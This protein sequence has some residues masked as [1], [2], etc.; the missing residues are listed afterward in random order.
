MWRS[1][2]RSLLTATRLFGQQFD[3][4]CDLPVN[5]FDAPIHAVELVVNVGIDFVH[6]ILQ[7]VKS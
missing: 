6:F 2:R 3:K 1:I 4:L 5:L 7:T